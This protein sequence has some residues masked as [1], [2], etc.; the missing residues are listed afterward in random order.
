[1]FYY[2]KEG[3]EKS[4]DSLNVGINCNVRKIGKK[5]I[6]FFCDHQNQNILLIQPANHK[7][8]YDYE[9]ELAKGNCFD[10]DTWM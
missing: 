3:D 7:K 1:M 4:K 2:K 10:I 9:K 6:T 8:N 5:E